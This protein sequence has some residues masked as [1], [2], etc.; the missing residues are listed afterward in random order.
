MPQNLTPK[1]LSLPT[2]VAVFICRYWTWDV[3]DSLQS[4][5]TCRNV[6]AVLLASCCRYFL[7]PEQPVSVFFV[8]WSQSTLA[9][10]TQTHMKWRYGSYWGGQRQ[11]IEPSD[12][13]PCRSWLKITTGTVRRADDGC[14]WLIFVPLFP[15][16]N[17]ASPSP[18]HRLPVSDGRTG[19]RPADCGGLG[20]D[21]PGRPSILP[22]QTVAA[23]P[24]RCK[25]S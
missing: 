5:S 8:F 25:Y 2:V 15:I 10:W 9:T 16:M 18:P 23:A 6:F 11:P 4:L 12:F 24:A 13:S 19:H 14:K 17:P 20:P 22:A 1:G 7:N 3:I 21:S